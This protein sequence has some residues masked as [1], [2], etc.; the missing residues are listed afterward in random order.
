MF[1]SR[2]NHILTDNFYYNIKVNHN[3]KELKAEFEKE[4]KTLG[5]TVS[6]SRA[7]VNKLEKNRQS[8]PKI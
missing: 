2:K 7:L 8:K 5:A 1:K 6:K 3:M 4:D